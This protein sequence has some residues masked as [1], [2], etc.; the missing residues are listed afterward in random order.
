MGARTEPGEVNEAA[1]LRIGVDGTTPHSVDDPCAEYPAVKAL[2]I[3]LK[4]RLS[5]RRLGGIRTTDPLGLG[6]R[7][8]PSFRPAFTRDTNSAYSEGVRFVTGAPFHFCESRGR[9]PLRLLALLP[10]VGIL[11]GV[12]FVN[13]VE[14]LVFGMPFV[15]AWIVGWII[16]SAVIMGIIYALDPSNRMR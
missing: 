9:M 6:G 1:S 7:C 4:T 2:S 14:P 11:V 10:F 12:A 8:D 13:H 3:R 15:L 5:R 16:L